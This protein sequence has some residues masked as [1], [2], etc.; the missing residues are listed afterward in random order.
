MSTDIVPYTPPEIEPYKSDF[1]YLDNEDATGL[2]AAAGYVLLEI[3]EAE[4]HFTNIGYR[5]LAVRPKLKKE[6]RFESWCEFHFSHKFSYS[7][8]ANYI[9]VVEKLPEYIARNDSITSRAKYV[10]TSGKPDTWR[11][12]AGVKLAEIGQLDEHAA[13]IVRYAPEPI[14]RLYLAGELPKTATRLFVDSFK[15][16]PKESPDLKE[17]II[18]WQV[19]NHEVMD[20]LKE[21]HAKWVKTRNDER[22]AESWL[23]LVDENGLLCGFD[24]SIRVNDP[25]APAFIA[26]HRVDRRELH[27]LENSTPNP[28][29]IEYDWSANRRGC[30]KVINGETVM[31]LDPEIARKVTDGETVIYRMRTR[32]KK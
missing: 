29:P 23:S 4:W 30:I 31:V 2:D 18:E 1:P 12:D 25:Q 24:W 8:L 6:K 32:R 27:I 17:K 19:C 5:L 28:N 11:I 14:T 20:Y 16:I 10:L 22:P 3:A 15:A 7:T 21:I 9:D 13:H 26:R